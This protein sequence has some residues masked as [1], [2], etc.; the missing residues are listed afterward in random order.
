MH[1]HTRPRGDCLSHTGTESI[2][3][4]IPAYNDAENIGVVIE[5]S[6]AILPRLAETYEIVI[7][8]D[9]S[10]D[11]TRTVIADYAARDPH[12]RAF[13][14][15]E[16]IGCHATE[17]KGFSLAHGDLL[18]FIPSD[19]Q[20]MP[21]QLPRCLE[22]IA[23]ADYV[24]TNR[25]QRADP[26]YRQMISHVYNASLRTLFDVPVHDVNSTVLVRR[27]VIDRIGADIKATST[28]IAVE[29]VIRAQAAGFR[30]AEVPIEHHPRVAG[31]ARGLRPKDLVKIPVNLV[32]FWFGLLRLRRE[33]RTS[34][35][36]APQ[37]AANVGDTD[38]GAPS[39]A[40]RRT[41]IAEARQE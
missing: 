30:I 29:L 36:G 35:R 7:V 1:E 24:C 23:D 10:S 17:L 22:A 19:R 20:I 38:D 26:K 6:L 5:A 2:S 27:T 16:N 9:V 8:D 3:I 25:V 31:K 11:E 4:V 13:H 39:D 12:I 14:N 37:K 18:F 21:D 40:D 32:G 33:L 34:G 15:A 41:V 28:F